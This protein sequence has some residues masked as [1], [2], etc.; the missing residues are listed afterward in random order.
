MPEE[1][2]PVEAVAH[3]DEEDCQD[4]R[5]VA[6][7]QKHAYNGQHAVF[8]IFLAFLLISYIP[9]FICPIRFRVHVG[10]LRLQASQK[11]VSNVLHILFAASSIHEEKFRKQ[12]KTHFLLALLMFSNF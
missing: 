8:A 1:K 12:L 11:N 5:S 6:Y 10:F 9:T 2:A 7:V 3:S 4:P